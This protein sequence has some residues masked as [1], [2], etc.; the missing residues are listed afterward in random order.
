MIGMHHEA[1]RFSLNE[2]HTQ[3]VGHVDV[4]HGRGSVHGRREVPAKTSIEAHVLHAFGEGDPR[5]S[6]QVVAGRVAGVVKSGLL[7]ERGRLIAEGTGP[8]HA[9]IQNILLAYLYRAVPVR[10]GMAREYKRILEGIQRSVTATLSWC[11]NAGSIVQGVFAPEREAGL[12]RMLEYAHTR[13]VALEAVCAR[14]AGETGGTVY[15]DIFHNSEIDAHDEVDAVE[16]VYGWDTERGVPS[17]VHYAALAQVKSPGWLSG[18]ER[19]RSLR[20]EAVHRAHTGLLDRL[21]RYPLERFAP[22]DHREAIDTSRFAES[23][24][25]LVGLFKLG[26]D[27]PDEA[28]EIIEHDVPKGD[29]RISAAY[30]ASVEVCVRTVCRDAESDNLFCRGLLEKLRAKLTPHTQRTHAHA[31]RAQDVLVALPD[32]V[33]SVVYVGGTLAHEKA[34]PVPVGD[35]APGLVYR[36]VTEKTGAKR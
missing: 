7:D 9:E 33:R 20:E 35:S 8:V 30:Y 34:L 10:E 1:G 16:L 32:E 22:R 36:K 23:S 11:P 14:M 4:R 28:W 2:A 18:G 6:L 29:E 5:E 17:A 3:P 24:A 13:A 19:E 21:V 12:M 27:N 25:D 31:L 15:Y 26:E